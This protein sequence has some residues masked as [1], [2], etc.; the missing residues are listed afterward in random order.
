MKRI[1]CFCLALGVHLHILAQK[2]DYVFEQITSEAGITF[3]AVSSIV[4]D[5]D[6][7][8]WF[9]TASGLYYYNTSE[10]IQY[11]YD[12]LNENAPPSNHITNLYKDKLGKI[13]I[14]TNHGVCYFDEITHSFSRLAFKESNRFLNNKSVSYILPFTDEKY[15]IVIDGLLYHFDMDELVLREIHLGD[16]SHRVSFLGRLENDQIYVGTQDGKV[17]LN[18]GGISDFTPFYHASS[19]PITTIISANDD[20]WIGL[21]GGGVEVIGPDRKLL[22]RFKKEY[23]GNRHISNDRVREIV[24]RKNGEIWIGSV[25][26]ISI[27]DLEGIHNIN[28]DLRFNG[29]PHIGIFDLFVDRN[30]GVWAGTWS[31]GLAYYSEYMFKFSHIRMVRNH[32]TGSRNVISSFAED[33]DGSIWVGIE[34]DDL[35]KFNPEKMAFTEEEAPW[36]VSRIKSISTD[37]NNRHWI[38]TLYNGLWSGKNNKFERIGDISGIFSAVLAVEDGVWVG[39]RLSGLIFYDTAKDTFTHYRAGD[40]AIGS[41]SSDH[42][43]KI[44]QDSKENIWICSNFGLSVKYKGAS[45][46]ERFFYNENANS[47]SRNLNYTITEDKNGKLWIGSAGAGIDI[48][49]PATKSF[50][51]FHLNAPIENAEVYCFLEDLRG[52]MW[53]STNQGIYTYNPTTQMI[54]NFTKQD[55]ILGKQYHPNS[56]F[57]S[58]SGKLFFGGGN[59]FNI[60]DPMTVKEKPLSA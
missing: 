12:P 45:D 20:I 19:N 9:G 39:S 44:F 51:K 16:Q 60:I 38:G 6:G 33:K 34:N 29:L 54:R 30:D 43:W 48:F 7:F 31:G 26:G 15:L 36:P 28:Q 53:F 1:V 49:D 40:K 24:K 23:S 27:Y 25:G 37:S 13:W 5:D 32:E 47:L 10:I 2:Q 35:K 41:I 55:G 59:G 56:G 14:C 42:I 22:T 50:Q 3:N 4:E 17:F 58:S 18:Q 11:S 52:N 21:F 8:L 57:I 46:F